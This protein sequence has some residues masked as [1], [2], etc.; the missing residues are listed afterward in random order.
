[1]DLP[2]VYRAAGATAESDI[3][4]CY[5]AVGSD[6]PTSVAVIVRRFLDATLGSSPRRPEAADLIKD[7]LGGYVDP[8]GVGH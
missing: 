2:V 3:A 8:L 7:V 1:V 4:W 6:G 5:G